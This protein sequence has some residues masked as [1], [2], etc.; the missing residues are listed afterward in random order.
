M[1]SSL[2]VTRVDW[3]TRFACQKS[4]LASIA[5]WRLIGLYFRGILHVFSLPSNCTII[6]AVYDSCHDRVAE[7]TNRDTKPVNSPRDRSV[8]STTLLAN[9]GQQVVECCLLLLYTGLELLAHNTYIF[10]SAYDQTG[11]P[12]PDQPECA[13]RGRMQDFLKGGGAT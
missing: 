10:T 1:E 7:A 3:W 5:H 11:H 13:C 6:P 12:F 4:R 2:N 9:L 8:V